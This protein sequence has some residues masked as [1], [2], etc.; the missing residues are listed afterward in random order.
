MALLLQLHHLG[1]QCPPP[2]SFHAPGDDDGAAA[3]P[4]P[5]A[6]ANECEWAGLPSATPAPMNGSATGTTAQYA[7]STSSPT[8]KYAITTLGATPRTLRARCEYLA[9]GVVG[10]QD[11]Y[12]YTLASS[13]V[14]SA[15]TSSSSDTS[16][17]CS[18]SRSR[19]RSPSQRRTTDFATQHTA[20]FALQHTPA[21][22]D[23][24]Q[25]RAH[26]PIA[27][28][29]SPASAASDD[30]RE[31]DE[32][33]AEMVYVPWS[34]KA[35]EHRAAPQ[36]AD[37]HAQHDPASSDTRAWAAEQA[38]RMRRLRVVPAAPLPDPYAHT[39]RQQQQAQPQYGCVGGGGYA[40][41]WGMRSARTSLVRVGGSPPRYQG[42]AQQQQTGHQRHAA[43]HA[44]TTTQWTPPPRVRD[45][46]ARAVDAAT[47]AA[48]CGLGAVESGAGEMVPSHAPRVPSHRL[49]PP[50]HTHVPSHTL[51]QL[52]PL[53]QAPMPRHAVFANADPSGMSGYVYA[54]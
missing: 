22:A 51:P 3:A 17:S 49:A 7:L 10:Q 47:A 50:A 2:S 14:S 43:L 39:Y 13:P 30:R 28:L 38:R 12:F 41:R 54:Y 1:V 44:R 46:R 36:H 8:P 4:A 26:R 33:D 37:H 19:L 6:H 5:R 18:A 21:A 11:L 52:A 31:S 29:S 35:R 15:S 42:A 34:S 9:Q 23:F 45:G 25:P 16:E 32:G 48:L 27:Y 24:A 40:G 20:D 53:T